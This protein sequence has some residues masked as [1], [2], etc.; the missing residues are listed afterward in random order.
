MAD[1]AATAVE[2]VHRGRHASTFCA[3]TRR[4]TGCAR[5]RARLRGA[6]RRSLVFRRRTRRSCRRRPAPVAA[7]YIVQRGLVGAPR[8][9]TRRPSPTRRSDRASAFRSARCRPAARRPRSSTRSRTR[10]AM[11]LPR[12]RLPGVAA[13]S[14]RVRA[15]LHAGDHRNAAPVA[16]TACYTPLQPARGASSRRS[17]GRWRELVA[18]RAGHVPRPRRRCA[19]PL[20]KMAERRCARSSSSTGRGTPVGLLT[21]VDL[22]ERVVLAG[23][24]LDDAGGRGHVDAD[25]IA[26]R[27]GHRV[28]G[29]ARDGASAAS[30]RSSSSKAGGC[31]AWSTSAICSRC[32]G[33][34]C[35]T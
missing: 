28:R 8:R 10:S 16:A 7:L 20:Q 17:R 29:D 6:P 11:L 3:G 35:A 1:I 18:A 21:L 2:P 19:R 26:A 9:T 22:L 25:R 32:S 33:C 12:A 24:P 14:P 5:G 23:R 27:I 31:W 4:S 15:L 34:R 30:A 13:A